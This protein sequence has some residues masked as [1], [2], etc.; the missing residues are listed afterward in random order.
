MMDA[1]KL[2]RRITIQAPSE[3]KDP[4][5]QPF[6]VWRDVVT[7]WAAITAP[8]SREIYSLGPGFTA[9][10]THKVVI[11]YREGISSA[12]RVAYR[13]RIFQIQAISD[14]D[15]GCVQL[16]MMCLEIADGGR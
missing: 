13:G 10:I 14:P 1:G 12:M 7:T 6:N 5:G 8:T 11:R 3:A 9:Q 16:I 4:Y 15:E 2:N